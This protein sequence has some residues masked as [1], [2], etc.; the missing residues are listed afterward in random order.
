MRL[1]SYFAIAAFFILL[2]AACGE[3][4]PSAKIET[5]DG[6]Q[7]IHNPE[8]PLHPEKTVT[9]E[10]ELAINEE[11]ANGNIILY[12]P[13]LIAI[14][15]EG[16][17]CIFDS[18]DFS[19]K[20]FSP[21]GTFVKSIGRQGEGPGEFQSIGP[22]KFFPDGRL[23]VLDWRTRRTSFFD[24]KGKFQNSYPWRN[25]HFECFWITENSLTID[26]FIYGEKT[27][28]FVKTFDFTGK[29]IKSIGE[30]K[31]RRPKILT[32]GGMSFAMGIPYTPHSILCADPA[33][34][35]LYHCMNDNYMIEVFDEG[36][37]LIRK[38]DRPYTPVPYTS[39]EQQ[40]FR[41]QADERPDTPF[42]K[43]VKDMMLPS[44][45]TITERMLVD[46]Q[47][48]LWVKTFEKKKQGERTYLAYDIFNP[49]GLYEA[50]I[51]S[52]IRP[53]IFKDNKVY[54]L[55]TDEETGFRTAKRY[56][57]V[58]KQND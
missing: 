42:S 28:L 10:K 45:K 34:E 53:Q 36:G 50:R 3:N 1:T 16:N 55:E 21:E 26:E 24:P 39:E 17:I 20:V 56:R 47:G 32:E 22:M 35:L 51:W 19:I 44:I 41:K 8:I 29:E 11:D 57:V 38:L 15:S 52:D 25:N 6:V 4:A 23:L 14:D 13:S 43:M 2:F 58:W 49:E 48:N 31:P 33:R 30:F 9:F 54:T 18:Q 40:E 37:N 5:I 7:H 46:D 27:Q 12:K